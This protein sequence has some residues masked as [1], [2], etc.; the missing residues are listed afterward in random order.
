M[1]PMDQE[2]LAE[3]KALESTGHTDDPAYETPS[4]PHRSSR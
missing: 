4:H 1:P 3:I 2:A